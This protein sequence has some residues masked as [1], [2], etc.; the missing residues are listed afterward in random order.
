MCHPNSFTFT[1][2]IL[3]QTSKH[4]TTV[5]L[6]YNRLKHTQKVPW[7]NCTKASTA[8]H[9]PNTLSWP[10]INTRRNISIDT[11]LTCWLILSRHSIDTQ[12]TSWSTLNYWHLIGSQ[13]IVGHVLIDSYV[14]ITTQWC[15]CKNSWFSTE[16]SIKCR[17]SVNRG[18][19][20]GSIEG[21]S[22]VSLDTQPLM[23]LVHMIRYH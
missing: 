23:H 16:M 20:R 21:R 1:L 7:I 5:I 10:L 4:W 17:S 12:S 14:S 11:W 3:F 2:K 19:N 18:V 13:L 6:I 8:E 15:V 9:Q 22:R